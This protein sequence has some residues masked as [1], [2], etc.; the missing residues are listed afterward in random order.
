M[1]S[2]RGKKNNN[3]IVK[4]NILQNTWWKIAINAMM[5]NVGQEMKGVASI[6]N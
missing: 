3:Y 2:K 5:I 4:L 6:I 1:E